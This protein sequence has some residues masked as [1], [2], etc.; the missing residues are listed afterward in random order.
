MIEIIPNWH[1]MFVH[2]TVALLMVSFVAFLIARFGPSYNVRYQA[3]VYA[4]WNLWIGSAITLLTLAAGFY[5][6]NTVDHDTP[7]HLAMTEHRNWALVTVL[8][9][10]C[11]T[12][13]SIVHSKKD[14]DESLGFMAILFISV[15][16]LVTTAWHGAELVYRHGLGVISLPQS[17]GEGHG[18]SHGD[19][20]AH[21]NG[22]DPMGSH[23]NSI[24]SPKNQ[25]HDDGHNHTH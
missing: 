15:T 1:P 11:L 5:A 16:L 8:M 12:I 4:R 18:H 23:R 9:Y 19:G 20:A 6:Y 25:A 13:L 10:F 7:S 2:F 22:D 17:S 14:H 24:D 21:G 3:R